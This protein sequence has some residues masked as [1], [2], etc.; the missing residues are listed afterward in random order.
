M[1]KNQETSLIL[2]AQAHNT[3][4]HN[5][6]CNVDYELENRM[7]KF[8][9]MYLNHHNKLCRS[10]L[11]SKVN[12]KNSTFT[13]NYHYLSCKYDWSHSDW[14]IDTSHLLCKV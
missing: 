9:H 2:P 3:V 5:L 13:S 7:L 8:T 6:T 14:C 4:V 11:L 12:C 10:L 1:E